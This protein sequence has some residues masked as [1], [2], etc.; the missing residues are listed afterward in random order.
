M[1]IEVTA[2]DIEEGEPWNSWRCPI[3][4]AAARGRGLERGDAFVTTKEIAIRRPGGW[5]YYA[6]PDTARAFIRAFDLGESVDPITFET[7]ETDA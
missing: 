6:L 5:D 4:L 2:Q 1:R 7:T 3:A